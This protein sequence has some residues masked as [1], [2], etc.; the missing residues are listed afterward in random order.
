MKLIQLKYFVEVVKHQC[1]ISNAARHIFTSQAGVS[2]QILLLEEELNVPLFFRKGKHLVEL[3]VEGKQ[4]YREAMNL[5]DKVQ[6]IKNIALDVNNQ[7]GLLT[8]ATTH[9]Q[10]RY[11]LP[12][13]VNRF[14]AEN[15]NI[16]FSMQQGNPKNVALLLKQGDVDLAIA[17]ESLS[18]DDQILAM[19]CYRWGRCIIVKKGHSLANCQALQLSDIVKYPI[20]TYVYGFTGRYKIDEV[21]AER[22]LSPNIVLTAV[23]ADV[24]KTYVRLGLGIGIVAKMAYLPEIDCDLVAIDVEN[25]F[26][27]STTQIALSKNKYIRKYIYRFIEM[28]SPHLSEEVVKRAMSCATTAERNGLFADFSIPK[29]K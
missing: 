19:P 23:D 26:G 15:S 6:S 22:K 27:V 17:T 1:N 18:S 21:F 4:V 9:T 5:L 10:A 7:E 13:I 20:I 25:I 24:I 8:I 3:T 14:I 28:F 29:I 2:K 12:P 11:V 16:Q